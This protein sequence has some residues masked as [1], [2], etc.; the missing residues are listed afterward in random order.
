M[1]T[2]KQANFIKDY[3][4]TFARMALPFIKAAGEAKTSEDEN[5]TGADD[6]QGQG[7]IYVAA[8]LEALLKGKPLPKQPAALNQ[9]G[10]SPE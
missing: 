10:S 7:L 2:K 5:D 3:W 9:S 1:S 6:L 4:K 8:L